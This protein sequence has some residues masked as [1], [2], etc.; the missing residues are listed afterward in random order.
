VTESSAMPKTRWFLDG[1]QSGAVLLVVLVTFAVFAPVLH[2]A[3]VEWDDPS[4]VTE[5]A[6][7]RA[8]LSA[9]GIA[10]AFRSTE[11][12]NWH[13]LTWLSHMLDVSLF[14]LA[15]WGHHLTSL[16]LHLAN[17]VLLFVALRR[18]TGSPWR[19]LVVAALFALHPLHVE[20][21][22]WIAERKNV[23]STAFWFATLWA[24][25]R[26]AE[27]P[28]PE[29]YALVVLSF[30]L[31][32]MAKPMLVSLPLTLLIVDGWPLRRAGGGKLA[33][34]WPLVVEKVP[35]FAMSLAASLTAVLAQRSYRG[36]MTDS[37]LT[38]RMANAV[39]GYFA[40]LEKTLWPSGL[41]TFY[42]YR[43]HPPAAEV[44]WKAAALVLLTVTL[45]WLGR[46][47]P[48][49]WAGWLWYL[50]TLLP[51]IGLVRIGQQEFADRYSYVP[52]VG[53]FVMFVWGFAD[54]VARM[55]MPRA[56][57]AANGLAAALLLAVLAVGA[58]WQVDTW[59]DGVTLW[60]RVLAVGGNSTVSQNN[61][62]VALE[63]VGRLEEAASHD[64]EAIRL[65]PRNARAYANLGDV[66]FA[67]GRYA[68]AIPSYEE[69]LR[70]IPDQEPARQNLAKA[71]YNVGNSLWRDGHPD[72]AVHEYR[73]AIRWK[74]D[75]AGFQR[76]LG[77]ALIQQGHH[78]EAVT[79]IQRSLELDPE[80]PYTHDALAV[81]LFERG[82]YVGARREVEV[83]R[84]RGGKPTPW[85][86]TELEHRPR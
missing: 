62:G 55:R 59:R 68:E 34:W 4:Y 35:L 11:L 21:V 57:R 15:P 65:E 41:S 19:S 72:E 82:D 28:T 39:L 44:A 73:E 3:F 5:N 14:G 17:T 58:R 42:P 76:A 66:R 60:E 48:Y 10:W 32:L 40:Y 37:P 79:V 61:L 22:A 8:G 18:L 86:V 45:T 6:H 24:H 20:S 75:D 38:A 84:A 25:A 12:A 83:C 78:D 77:M 81:A 80:N 64:A 70:L 67:Q 7:V 23:L 9:S 30:A 47:R 31:G 56:E 16:L 49:L 43:P 71:H 63:K 50:V 52:L 54:V 29:R 53:V 69:A 51:V 46:R 27:R 26:F 74:P 33:A 1:R 13:P 36:A 2:H 85:L